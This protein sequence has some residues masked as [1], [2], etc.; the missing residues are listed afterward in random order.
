MLYILCCRLFT[1]T[2]Q[3]KKWRVLKLKYSSNIGF[4]QMIMKH[5]LT[6]S[7]KSPASKL[8]LLMRGKCRQE[9]YCTC[10]KEHQKSCCTM[11]DIKSVV[12][13][14]SHAV[15]DPQCYNESNILGMHF[16]K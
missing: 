16:V 10:K 13:F 2:K 5:C 9:K 12:L 8:V 3:D 15:H 6:K 7:S 11:A 4:F 1:I 14:L